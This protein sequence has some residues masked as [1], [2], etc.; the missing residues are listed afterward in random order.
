M[1][2]GSEELA[3]ILGFKN[4]NYISELVKDKGMPKEDWNK[5]DLYKVIPW[6]LQLKE[7]QYKDEIRKV[8]AEK[9]QDDLARKS[10]E[11]KDLQIQEMKGALVDK[12]QVLAAVLSLIGVLK[13]A[14]KSLSP[15]VAPQLT[16]E[17]DVKVI[18][19]KIDEEVTRIFRKVGSLKIKNTGK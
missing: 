2:V 16:S 17:A 11:L 14:F 18:R 10:T 13:S 8:R 9:P 5:F 4:R 1:I 3:R 12:E 19:K 6:F 15:K 7:E